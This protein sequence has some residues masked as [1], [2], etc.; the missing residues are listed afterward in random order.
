MPCVI[1][2]EIFYVIV[3]TYSLQYKGEKKHT[4]PLL[5]VIFNRQE[6]NI[7]LIVYLTY[8]MDDHSKGLKI[9]TK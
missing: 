8:P 9:W 1:S 5:L 2:P 3:Y 7:P 4:R 6:I